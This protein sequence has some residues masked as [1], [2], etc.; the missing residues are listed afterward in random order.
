MTCGLTIPASEGAKTY[1]LCPI[2]IHNDKLQVFISTDEQGSVSLK[3]L[4]E[5][6]NAY[7]GSET[8]SIV[9]DQM[10]G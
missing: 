3:D 6:I 2:I 10:R 4:A 5:L 9:V 8:L 7:D 1:D